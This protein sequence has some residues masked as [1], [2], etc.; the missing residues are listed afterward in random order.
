MEFYHDVIDKRRFFFYYYT[1]FSWAA[2]YSNVARDIIQIESFVPIRSHHR[3][4]L[5]IT[6]FRWFL[7]SRTRIALE[8]RYLSERTRT[9]LARVVKK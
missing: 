3:R 9:S 2:I 4:S 7:E 8:I 1:H 6:L 5:S